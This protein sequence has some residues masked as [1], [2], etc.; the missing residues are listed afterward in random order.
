MSANGRK[1][2]RL[3][4]A[5]VLSVGDARGTARTYTVNGACAIGRASTNDLVLAR[6][7]VSRNHAVV[8]VS[9]G[10]VV[11]RDLGSLNGT[12]V[13]GLR[14]SGDWTLSD[15]DLIAIGD[16]PPIGVRIRI[17]DRAPRAPRTRTLKYPRA[18]GTTVLAL[19]LA[20][21]IV[22]L[23]IVAVAYTSAAEGDRAAAPESS[24][25]PLAVV[26]TA[27]EAAPAEAA[28]DV[29]AAPAASA[30]A[31]TADVE[32]AAA[33]AVRRMSADD[34]AYAFHDAALAD[35]AAR[36]ADYRSSASLPAALAELSRDGRDV[37]EAARAEGLPPD[38][39]FYAA[40]AETDGGRTGDALAA[41][42]QMVP[43]LAWLRKTFGG[44]AGDASLLVVAA[45]KV[46]GKGSTS[47]HPLLAR[48]RHFAS[49]DPATRRNVWYLRERGA[50]D[51]EAYSFVVRTIALG[52]IAQNPRQFG[53]VA[54]TLIL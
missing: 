44:E 54:P 5:V 30:S 17:E 31:K 48:L 24:P 9:G 7:G 35:I 42:R 46:G 23:A 1:R 3:E 32:R 52:A 50:L 10:R 22:G 13:N 43:T 19:G 33:L 40:L 49:D 14:V 45:Y 47:S 6:E 2:R 8:E 39:V 51:D 25:S 11:A 21:A 27:P 28:P 38:L 37:A 41:A 29:V 53:V 4:V 12:F 26:T 16:G 18:T 34:E 20:T 15:G 36:V